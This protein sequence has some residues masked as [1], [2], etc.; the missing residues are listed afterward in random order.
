MKVVV[1]GASGH[2]GRRVVAELLLRGHDVVAFVYNASKFEKH[3]SLR[4]VS[5]DVK[6]LKDVQ[7]AFRDCEIAISA[8]GSWDTKTK[9][10]LSSGMR[11]VIPVMEE[12]GMSRIISLT[13]HEARDSADQPSAINTL[14]RLGLMLV[15]GKILRDGEEHIKLLRQSKLDWTV[16]RSPLMNEKGHT[17][18]VFSDSLTPPWLTIHRQAVAVA[19]VELLESGD[20]SKQSPVIRRA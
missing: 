1:L 15:A 11:S 8:L 7:E 3:D 2:V 10:I 14:A 20:Y 19:M 4:V 13:G 18:Y 12:N 9:D 17:K 6:N 5:G 16:V